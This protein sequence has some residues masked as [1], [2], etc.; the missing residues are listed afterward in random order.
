MTDRKPLLTA[1]LLATL[2]PAAALANLTVGEQVLTDEAAIRAAFEE[3]GLTV[4][5]IEFED[6]E[7]EVEYSL[8]GQAY[9]VSISA[10]TGMI[11]EIE[12]EDEE[13]DD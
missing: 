9:E 7:I 5:E 6:E 3:K 8:D 11:T 12:L 13:D 4:T 10:S 1:A 2:I